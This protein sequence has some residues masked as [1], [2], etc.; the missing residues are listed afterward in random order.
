MSWGLIVGGPPRHSTDCAPL[1]PCG[2]SSAHPKKGQ[3]YDHLRFRPDSLHPRHFTTIR[4]AIALRVHSELY[5]T[6]GDFRTQAGM[7]AHVPTD[8]DVGHFITSVAK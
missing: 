7:K 3:A 5:S 1:R 8:R 6:S 2:A 4:D